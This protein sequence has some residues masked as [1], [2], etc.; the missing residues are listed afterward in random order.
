[1]DNSTLQQPVELKVE[2]GSR[3]T[4]DEIFKLSGLYARDS[5]GN[6]LMGQLHLGDGGVQ[7]D[8]I[9]VTESNEVDVTAYFEVAGTFYNT[10]RQFTGSWCWGTKAWN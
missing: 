10:A 4:R 6:S 8:G 5:A 2:R 7:D 9:T 3:V 1:M